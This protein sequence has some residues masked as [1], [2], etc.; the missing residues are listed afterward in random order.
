VLTAWPRSAQLAVAF[1]LG[2]IV[3]LLT[4][5]V[6]GYLPWAS[7][8]T[9][10]DRRSELTYRIDVNRADRAELLQLPGVGDA[11]AGRIE[12]YR[13]QHGRFQGVEQLR[14]VKGVG[15]ARLAN[16]RPFIEIGPETEEKPATE[17]SA[18]SAAPKHPPK[19]A[20]L[21]QPIDIN[22]ASVTELQRL[23]GVGPK[24][25]ERIIAERQ[26]K[27]FASVEDLR[28]VPRIGP[29]TLERLRPHVTVA[30]HEA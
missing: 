17:K 29:K 5:Q 11:L 26:K 9:N 30:A 23:P 2:V 8:P 22:R 3:T 19:G 12:E 20:D 24:T 14:Q 1:L 27:P 25:A 13:R 16:L 6:W 21:T 10:L 15:P 18:R 28:R 4:V 7:R